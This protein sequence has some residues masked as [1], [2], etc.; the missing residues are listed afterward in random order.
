VKLEIVSM[1]GGVGSQL[2]FNT[3]L[4]RSGYVNINTNG[5]MASLISKL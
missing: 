3:P 5:R 4:S 2:F 1:G